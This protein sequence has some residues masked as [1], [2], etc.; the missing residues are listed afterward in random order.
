MFT[1]R[2]HPEILNKTT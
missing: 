2:E 1:S